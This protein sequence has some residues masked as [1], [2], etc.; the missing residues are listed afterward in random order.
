ML[1]VLVNKYYLY[2]IYCFLFIYATN[3]IREYKHFTYQYEIECM[4]LILLRWICMIKY[5]D[6]CAKD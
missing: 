4:M 1:K 2:I 5:Q 3:I 6:H